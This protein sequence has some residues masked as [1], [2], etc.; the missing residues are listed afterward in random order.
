MNYLVLDKIM[1]TL[2]TGE[3]GLA[4]Q[5]QTGDWILVY[6]RNPRATRPERLHGATF[7][8]VVDH[9]PEETK[10]VGNSRV[11]LRFRGSISGKTC[12]QK[13]GSL[14]ESHKQR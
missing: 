12:V 10:Q 4:E 8:D 7:F 11:R 9:L 5:T 13:T 1:K 2:N 3:I 6:S 14:L